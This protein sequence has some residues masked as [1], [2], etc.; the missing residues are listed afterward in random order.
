MIIFFL[1]FGRP[2]LRRKVR[3]LISEIQ[4]SFMDCGDTVDALESI[5][6]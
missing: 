1:E 3:E 2:N 4:P 5:G 6:D